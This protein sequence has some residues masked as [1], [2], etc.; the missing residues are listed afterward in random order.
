M[1]LFLYRRIVMKVSEELAPLNL[2]V[3]AQIPYGC[4]ATYGQIA[5]LAGL[6]KHARL[7]GYLLKNLDQN[8]DLPWHRV[9][10]SQGKIRTYTLQQGQNLQRN[11]LIQE[12]V[13]VNCDR[14]HL[15]Q[16]IWQC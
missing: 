13:L 7:V 6:P 15:K 12:G 2:N 16:Y 10:N 1:W 9:V 4:V 14:I 3:V 5:T 11:L 8:S